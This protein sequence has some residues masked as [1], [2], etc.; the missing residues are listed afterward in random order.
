MLIQLLVVI[1]KTKNFERIARVRYIQR[2]ATVL[3]G[4]INNDS[5]TGFIDGSIPVVCFIFAAT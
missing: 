2:N 5:N 4:A 3:T 1:D